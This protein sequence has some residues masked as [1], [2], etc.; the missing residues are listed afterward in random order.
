MRILKHLIKVAKSYL[1]RIGCKHERFHTAS[2][3]FTGYTYVTCDKCMKYLSVTE[4]KN[5]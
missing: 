1:V 2:C 5:G 3:P 4:T